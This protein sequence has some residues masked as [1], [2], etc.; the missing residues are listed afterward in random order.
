VSSAASAQ[1]LLASANMQELEAGRQL[2][3]QYAAALEAEAA[4]RQA[5]I[6]FLASLLAQQ[7]PPN[8]HVCMHASFIDSAWHAG[9]LGVPVGRPCGRKISWSSDAPA[10]A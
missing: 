2:L 9:D 4:A 6:G 1:G 7:V 5:A 8:L 10:A 3:G